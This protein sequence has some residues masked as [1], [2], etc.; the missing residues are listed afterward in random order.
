[1]NAGDLL[2]RCLRWFIVLVALFVLVGAGPSRSIEVS[3]KLRISHPGDP[4]SQPIPVTL[5]QSLDTHGEP[6]AYHMWVDSVIC[7]EQNC[8]VVKVKLHW[9]ALGKYQRYEVAKGSKL[10]KLD[11]VPFTDADH[12]KLQS[13]LSDRN[14][15]LM[16][17]TK[18]GLTGPKSKGV[19]GVSG[20]T[21]LT[22]K[23]NVVVGAGYCCYDLWHWANGEVA[24][25]VRA[26]SGQRFSEAALKKLLNSDK[27]AAISF[28]L[29]HLRKRKLFDRE[30]A[31]AVARSMRR[32]SDKLIDPALTY[33]K[34]AA[35]NDAAY[36]DDIVIIFS[37][38]SEEKR[39]HIITSLSD[40]K[41]IPKNVYDR[42]SSAMPKFNSHH[43]LHLLLA[44][45]TSRGAGSDEINQNA[46]RLLK[47]KKFFVARRAY[48]YLKKQTLSP[49]VK[50]QVDAFHKKHRLRL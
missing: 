49:D 33:L 25:I 2:S 27:D 35:P 50:A 26:Q 31:I 4:N 15:P 47:H 39:V 23:S 45:I 18:E 1:M 28:A 24:D 17:V 12:A 34:A 3:H 42:L 13:I 22:L 43:E 11:H 40:D 19:D 46:A 5:V 41:R 9:N 21:V 7:R 16:E 30:T 44:L 37:D 14:S 20:A 8:Q 10:T 36:Y 29:V 6:S 32:A 48:W 38:C